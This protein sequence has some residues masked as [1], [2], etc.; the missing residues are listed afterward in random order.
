MVLGITSLG[1][2]VPKWR[3]LRQLAIDAVNRHA[4]EVARL[5]TGERS[6]CGIDEDALT[7]A[8]EAARGCLFGLDR[9]RTDGAYL[10]SSSLPFADRQNASVQKTALG[11]RDD[12]F[13]VDCTG[14]LR[15]GTSGLM[16]ALS[17]VK[18]KDLNTA[19]VTA[20]DRR[21]AS[22]GAPEELL[23]GHGAAAFLVGD[24]GVVAEYLGGHSIARDLPDHYRRSDKLTDYKWEE[25][26]SLEM[27]IV[28]LL[29]Q[30]ISSLLD[31]LG[32]KADDV[33][34]FVIPAS[35]K[36]A[37][38]KIVRS[39]GLAPERAADPLLENVGDT[40]A[41]HPLLLLAATLET[42]KSGQ[43]IVC[44]GIGGGCDVL[45]FRATDEIEKQRFRFGVSEAL[46]RRAPLSRYADFLSY[47]G[48]LTVDQGI[49]GE[50]Q[51][52][53]ALSV[54]FRE[55]KMILGLA[56]GKCESCGTPQFPKSRVCVNPGCR[57]VDT[58]GAYCFAELEARLRTYTADYLM[59]SGNPPCLYGLIQFDGGGRMPVELCDC[60]LD[61]LAV[62]TKVRMVFRKR[63]EDDE[64]GF[65]GYFWKATPVRKEEDAL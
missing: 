17:A 30:G 28:P 52:K 38:A 59:P 1:V 16:S 23:L 58:Q 49:R 35:S 19:L 51:T 46:G 8:V 29:K 53:T 14:S 56:G 40:G 4:L 37:H 63:Y 33:D 13:A 22:P 6:V 55:Q 31:K 9:A 7:M 50:I 64:R 32:L 10:C 54:L 45:L 57:K 42:A 25:R 44:V 26:W 2:Y 3:L 61:D 36:A 5:K 34:S 27:G 12:L 47:Q 41:A 60:G 65:V 18:A 21:L 62:G 24:T 39:L 43:I 20:S 15:A 48:L 11:L